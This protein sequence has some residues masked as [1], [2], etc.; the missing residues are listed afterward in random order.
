VFDADEANERRNKKK[1]IFEK[2]LRINKERRTPTMSSPTTPI[3]PLIPDMETA[4]PDDVITLILACTHPRLNLRAV[5]ITPGTP[6]QVAVV[7]SILRHIRSVEI[8]IGVFDLQHG[9]TRQEPAAADHSSASS[10]PL[11]TCVSEWHYK[12]F[13]HIGLRRDAVDADVERGWQLLARHWSADVTLVTGAPLKNLGAFLH[14]ATPEQLGAIGSWVAQGGFAGDN[15]V[16]ES[17]RLAQFRGRNF[18]QTYNFGGDIPSARRALACAQLSGKTSCVSKNVCH[19]VFFS[20][21]RLEFLSSIVEKLNA[22]QTSDDNDEPDDDDDWRAARLRA[23]RL[24]ECS[25]RA[26]L[27]KN[28]NGK[29]FHDPLALAAAIDASCVTWAAVRVVHKAKEGFGCETESQSETEQGRALP[30]RISIDCDE[31][32]AFEILFQV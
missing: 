2:T 14:N 29:K 5:L 27:T 3:V 7:R 31:D 20:K 13:A 9:S 6:A 22:M 32:R 12:S 15:V 25:M 11:P 24:V 16:P 17:L 30:H 26:Y 4:D 28:G 19:R 10:K 21:Q 18:F 23:L 8:P 1:L